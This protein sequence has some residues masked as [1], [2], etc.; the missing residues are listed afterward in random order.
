M[1]QV[2][3]NVG[4][5]LSIYTEFDDKKLLVDIGKSSEFN[6]IIEFLLP[7]FDKRKNEKHSQFDEKY[8]IDQL[9]VSHPH[10]DHISALEDF[11]THFYADLLTCPNDNEGMKESHKINW[12]MF[13]ESDTI[14]ILKEM[15]SGRTA[16]LRA[17]CDQN[18]F[19]YYLPPVEVEDDK[20]LSKESY[21]NNI[22][23]VVFLIVN[24]QRVFMP[25]DLQKLGMEILLESNHLLKNKLKGGVDVLVT[26]HHGLR[27]S[28]STALFNYMKNKKTS[29]LNIVSEKVNTGDKR[30]VDS[31][32]STTDFCEGQ[33]NLGTTA[34][35]SY[36]VKTSRG[37]I[38]ID[39]TKYNNP[40]FE[41]VTDVNELIGYF[42]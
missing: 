9:I 16:P 28:F 13:E 21:C 1:K 41:I 15:L 2:I 6:P 42:L 25:S 19:I 37:H 29:R 24:G 5:A 23:I 33:N 40:Y 27:S 8:R 4:G 38:F 7:L 26:P 20:E 30:E 12:E 17:T 36:Q 35:P 14:K 32:Y 10:K 11:N 34:N 3:F 39:Y 18:E 22:G 31:R